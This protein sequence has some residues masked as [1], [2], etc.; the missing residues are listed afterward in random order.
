M[1]G[2]RLC[3]SMKITLGK[4]QVS[5]LVRVWMEFFW[6]FSEERIKNSKKECERVLGFFFYK[7][8]MKLSHSLE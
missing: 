2:C 6:F 8:K 4:Q 1:S 7:T 3:K 5:C